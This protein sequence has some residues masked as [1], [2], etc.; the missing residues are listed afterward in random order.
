MYIDIANMTLEEV[1]KVTSL[2]GSA[3]IDAYLSKVGEH[4]YLYT[5]DKE[6]Y[7]RIMEPMMVEV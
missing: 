3:R 2:L 5:V 1:S 7:T 6:R 4:A